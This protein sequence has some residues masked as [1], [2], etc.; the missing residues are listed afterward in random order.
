ML[1]SKI[2]FL[3]V[4]FFGYLIGQENHWETLVFNS[5]IWHYY[6]GNSEPPSNWKE[7]LFNDD[8]WEANT[9]GIGYGDEDDD[10]IIDPV[11]SLYMRRE[12]NVVDKSDI[13]RLVL[14]ADYDDAFVAYLNGVEISRYNVEGNPP[15]HN[16]GANENHEAG[17]YRGILPEAF[18]LDAQQLETVLQEGQNVL[19]FQAHNFEGINSSDLSTNFFLS[20]GIFSDNYRY[21][22]LP[23]WFFIPPSPTGEFSTTLPI[24]KIDTDGV[25]IEDE[26]KIPGTMGIIW[27]GENSQNASTGEQNEFFGNISIEKRG[28]SSLWVF[29]KNGYA[30]ETKDET[31]EEDMDVSFLDFPEE[32]DWILHGPYSDKTLMRNV[33]AMHLANSLGGYHS[34]TRFV[35]LIVNDSYEGVYVMMERIKQDDNRVDIADLNPDEISGDDL[36]GGYVFK[37]DKDEADWFSNFDMLNVDFKLAFQFVSPKASKVVTE[38]RDY[39]RSYVDTFER[40]LNSPTLHFN[41]K[42]YD[43]YADLNSFVDHLIVKELSKDVDAYRISSYYYK[44]KDSNGGKVYAGP[45]WDFY[46]G[47]ANADYCDGADARGWQFESPICGETNPFWFKAMYEDLVFRNLLKCRWNAYRQGPLALD[48]IYAFIDEQAALLQPAINRN[49]NRWPVLG[50]YIWPNSQVFSNY[51][52]EVQYMKDFI[53]DRIDWMDQQLGSCTVSTNEIPGVQLDVFPNPFAD[54]ININLF[55]YEKASLRVE[56]FNPVGQWVFSQDLGETNIG[57]NVFIVDVPALSSGVYFCK[58]H[59]GVQIQ[60]FKLQHF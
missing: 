56:L 58:V 17:M 9:G 43:E 25:S 41:G 37:I 21:R 30:I 6:P 13:A 51:E 19:C 18:E 2:I 40:A 36:T 23:D 57:T 38:Q 34:R 1:K 39:I 10:T 50:Q 47:F 27:N 16:T 35:E 49:F 15:S 5:D 29:P 3:F 8:D 22:E 12:F 45:V 31:G 46:L 4:F 26:P 54:R 32:E 11:N 28:Q 48:S 53:S 44:R 42:R 20:A 33:L 60:T 7:L 55:H 24:L 59:L 14:H 52:D